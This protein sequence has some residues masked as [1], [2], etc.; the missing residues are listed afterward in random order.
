MTQETKSAASDRVHFHH[1][2]SG[3][4]GGRIRCRQNPRPE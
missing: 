4:G 1:D 2:R 3:R